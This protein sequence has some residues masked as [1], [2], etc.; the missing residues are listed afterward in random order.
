MKFVES[1]SKKQ[2]LIFSILFI[3]GAIFLFWKMQYGYIF[4]DEPFVLTLGHRLLKGDKLFINEWNGTQLCAF[5]NLPIIKLHSLIRNPAIE[6]VLFVRTIY[7][8][9]WLFVSYVIYRRF[10]QFGLIS[11]AV[12]LYF[13]LFTPLDTMS[14]TYNAMALSLFCL[15][16]TYFLVKG[17]VVTDV[18]TG[19]ALALGGIAS[20]YSVALYVAYAL[21]VIVVNITKLKDK[22]FASAKIFD[23]KVFINITIG[24]SLV[25]IAFFTYLHWVGFDNVFNSF[26]MIFMY[27][28]LPFANKIIA[29]IKVLVVDFPI[30]TV[31]GMLII[32]I[33]AFDKKR[34]E[35][36]LA[37]FTIQTVLWGLTMAYIMIRFFT[38]L[39]VIMMPLTVL[40]L[41]AFILTKNKN[42]NVFSS[43][44]IPGIIF[45]ICSNES[46]DTGI[47]AVS[48]ATTISGMGSFLLISLFAK[49]FN[50]ESEKIKRLVSFGLMIIVCVQLGSQF[51]IRC[52]RNYLDYITP[53][54][55]TKISIG[56]AKGIIT[57]KE[58]ALKYE[59]IY[60]D[61][62]IIKN[63]ASTDDNVLIASLFPS[64]YLDLDMNYGAYSS[65]T[66]IN[67]KKNF[68]DFTKRLGRYYD[69]HSEKMPKYIYVDNEDIGDLHLIDDVVNLENYDLVQG[70]RGM[71]FSK[72]RVGI[73][74]I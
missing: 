33:S 4:N 5:F 6:L 3:L 17:N 48:M 52:M 16:V 47:M 20:P 65:W 12:M 63:S 42:F 61:L 19:F 60:D 70:K 35:R 56:V 1:V 39:N 68:V 72:N 54:L 73:D 66:Y 40:G 55:D 45:A 30:Q 7:V 50:S 74:G 43:L 14:I 34:Y 32:V 18:L 2:S 15:F 24:A 59:E 28:K 51:T 27:R 11:L 36:R 53:R 29:I 41:Q 22:P 46:S 57:T 31:F 64:A 8:I 26:E 69:L 13:M 23:F 9:W 67:N 38:R 62:Q 21:A 49:E 25:G 58:R 10:K 44:W 71:I 37:Y